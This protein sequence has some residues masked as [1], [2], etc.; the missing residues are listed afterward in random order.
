MPSSKPLSGNIEE[1]IAWAEKM[2]ERGTY[3]TN[4]ANNRILALRKLTSI[5]GEDEKKDA[6]SL[7][8]N[9]DSYADRWARKEGA[10][11]SITTPNKSHVRRLLTEYLEFQKS[12]TGFRPGKK[13]VDIRKQ[14][15]KTVIK[16]AAKHKDGKP[17]LLN[18]SPAQL[19]SPSIHLDIQIHISPDASEKQIDAIF[20]SMAKHLNLK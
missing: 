20:E 13:P 10:T 5:L 18:Q 17:P 3:R 6:Q 19:S 15:G 11:A 8:D 14:K 7:L 16:S 4:T 9:L 1:V 2:K 12:P